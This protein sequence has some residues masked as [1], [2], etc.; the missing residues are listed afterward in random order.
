[1]LFT[2]RLGQP[3]IGIGLAM[4]REVVAAHSGHL[5]IQ[6]ETHSLRSGTRVRI[7]LPI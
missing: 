6:S 4:V 7:T 2:V 3:R 1:M 5:E